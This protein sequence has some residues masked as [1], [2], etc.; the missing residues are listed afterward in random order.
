MDWFPYDNGLRHER[1]KRK[2]NI[3]QVLFMC[4]NHSLCIKYF[5]LNYVKSALLPVANTQSPDETEC[6]R[7]LW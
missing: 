1:V 2:R 5:C 6:N 3:L 7:Q 4:E